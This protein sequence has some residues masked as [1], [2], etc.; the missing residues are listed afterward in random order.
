[1]RRSFGF[2]CCLAALTAL[3]ATSSAGHAAPAD[4]LT[5]AQIIARN[6]QARGGA[7]AWR[8]VRTLAM[9]GKLEAGSKQDPELPFVIKMKRDH[10]SRLEIRFQEQT[11]VQ[12]YDGRQGWKV[13]PFLGRDEVEPFTPGEA[14]EAM[15]WQELDG[16]LIDYAKKG[17]RAALEGKDAVEGRPAYRLKLTMKDGSQRRVWIDA[18][19]FLE[20]KMDGEPRVMDGKLRNVAIYYRDYRDEHGLNVPHVFETAVEGGNKS[21]RMNVEQVAINQPMED[22]LFAKPQTGLVNSSYK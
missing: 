4:R 5:A 19:S 17:T 18:Q 16:P 13:R 10:K 20:L 21:H 11:A 9:S 22:A 2:A 8:A 14:K 7:K 15:D 3:A 12:V 6:V 1:M